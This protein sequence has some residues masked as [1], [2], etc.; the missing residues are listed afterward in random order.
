MRGQ[1][2]EA[3]VTFGRTARRAAAGLVIV[4]GTAVTAA[5]VATAS[6]AVRGAPGVVGRTSVVPVPGDGFAPPSSDL[7][8]LGVEP[9]SLAGLS[10]VG[11]KSGPH[12]GA[13]K[14][15]AQGAV[16]VPTHAFAPGEQVTVRAPDLDVTGAVGAPYTFSTAVPAS[17]TDAAAA[18]RAAARTDAT[19]TTPR[20]GAPYVPPACPAPVYRSEPQLQAEGVCM[21]LGVR[22]SG[23]ASG[24]DLFL[25][26][27]NDDGAGIYSDDG[28]L[29]WWHPS[30]PGMIDLD[31]TVVHYDGHAYIAMWSGSFGLGSVLLYDDHYEP[32]GDVTAGGGFAP[33]SLDVHEFQITPAGDAL[34]GIYEPV[35]MQVDGATETV[36]QYVVQELSLVRGPQGLETGSVLFE[37]DSLTDVPPSE[38]QEPSPGAGGGGWDYFHGNA[39]NED[40]DGN[41]V[42]SARNT[43]G[44]YKIDDT[45]GDPDFGH[46][47]WQVGA[48]GDAQLSEPWCYQHDVNALGDDT[49]SLFDDGGAGPGCQPHSTQHPARALL[50]T[51]NP[52]TTPAGVRLDR[53]Y[54]HTP[55]ILTS[56]TGSAQVLPDG[57]MLVDWANVPEIT[58]YGATGAVKMDLTLT[59]ASYRGLRYAWTGDP[60]TPPSV[61]VAGSHGK[62]DVYAS[63]NGATDVTGWQVLGGVR[64]SAL[65]PIGR[66]AAVDGFETAI[67]VAQADPYVAVEALGPGG[68]ALST[69]AAVAVGGYLTLTASG[70]VAAT[71]GSLT[72][73]SK[74]PAALNAPTVAIAG[75]PDGRGY[76]LA[77]ADGGV[78]AYGDARFHGSLGA[79][80][81]HAPPVG[82]AATPDGGGYWLVAADGG[83]F[84]FG[85][86]RFH[87]SLGNVHLDK[88]IVGI[89]TTPTGRGYWLVAA[90]GGVFSFGDATFH[91]SLGGVH[92]G[93][94][95]VAIA[96]TP[97]G[98]GY[99]LVA[100]DGGVFTFGDAHFDGSAAG[101]AATP[102]VGVATT[103]D[104]LGYWLL[105]DAGQVI[106]FGGAPS[107]APPDAPP[108]TGSFVGIV[109]ALASPGPP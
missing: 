65:T 103:T 33:D 37:W 102:V 54:T 94:P 18:L 63:W 45:S 78:F 29:V 59:G 35:S 73:G 72:A 10:V 108:A 71:G 17:R 76:W 55:S 109:R 52:S 83:V 13:I 49:Y 67:A 60:L 46:V 2:R 100:S 79:V 77:A 62:L 42:V 7:T 101:V 66:P 64:P 39:I 22:T 99:W 28:Q 93:A 84:S 98:A 85:D 90:D 30:A 11:S 53:S 9:A 44:L 96:A 26:P 80:R 107:F 81:L 25:T 75:T 23:T 89:A 38:S 8:F 34:V 58:E 106:A 86:A 68:K 88:P 15:I 12:A 3:L 50:I 41:L 69:S 87:G 32:A 92:L 21:N 1:M 47:V 16:F 70:A 14:A 24:T 19:S 105:T 20:P 91:G 43:W 40:T 82:I 36:I 6:P 31:E 95:V 57:D 74:A 27:N 51:V 4:L 97:D 48:A 104:G 5:G 61:G 56:Y